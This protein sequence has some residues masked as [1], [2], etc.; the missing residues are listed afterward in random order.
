MSK[1]SLPLGFRLNNPGNIRYS[2]KNKWL[3]QIGQ[4]R[5]FCKFDDVEYGIRAMLY[6]L[7]K[8]VLVHKIFN[9]YDIIKRYAPASENDVDAY[10]RY[11]N[12][13][14]GLYNFDD[15]KKCLVITCYSELVRLAFYMS[16]YEVGQSFAPTL[17][18]F[19]HVYHKYFKEF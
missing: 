1:N 7:R 13:G 19:Y 8:Y 14:F 12:G 16:C 15:G 6:I 18:D 4:S 5:G 10:F 17:Y 2:K 11:V 9:V 3:G